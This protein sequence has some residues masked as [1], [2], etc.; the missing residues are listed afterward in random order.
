MSLSNEQTTSLP[1]SYIAHETSLSERQKCAK[2]LFYSAL[3]FLAA[4]FDA[5]VTDS[6]VF[7]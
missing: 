3:A 1:E 2:L 4:F 5:L 6:P 7:F